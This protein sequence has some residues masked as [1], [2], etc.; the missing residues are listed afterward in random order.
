MRERRRDQQLG[1]GVGNRKRERK[2]PRRCLPRRHQSNRGE[3]INL[4]VEALFDN[5]VDTER[6]V[7]VAQ[8]HDR[9]VAI[10]VV[11]HL[12]YLLLR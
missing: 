4:L 3:L 8:G 12:D 5:H 1:S 11:L 6:A 7:V 2:V 9:D 10:H